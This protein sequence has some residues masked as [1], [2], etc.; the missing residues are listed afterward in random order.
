MQCACDNFIAYSQEQQ[1]QGL[2]SDTR[3]IQ[4]LKELTRTD[5]KLWPVGVVR[6]Y[7]DRYNSKYTYMQ[8]VIGHFF[9][10]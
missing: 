6:S 7:K 1:E 9:A 4:G 3:L 10:P 5:I 8:I 2:I